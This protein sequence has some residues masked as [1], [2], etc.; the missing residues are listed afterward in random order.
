MPSP[1]VALMLEVFEVVLS[2]LFVIDV[3]LG[4]K[5]NYTNRKNRNYS[6]DI[7]IIRVQDSI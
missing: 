6:R 7:M 1:I 2:S 3:S 4:M 5:A